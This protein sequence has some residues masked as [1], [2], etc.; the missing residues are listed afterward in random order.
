MRRADRLFQVIQLLRAR[1]TATAAELADE[2]EV[3]ERTVYRDVR[4]LVACG[5][6]IEG[7]AGVGYVLDR[8]FDLPPLM[9]TGGELQALALG[10][11]MASAFADPE[12]A[13]EARGA[14][15]KIEAALPA[16]LRVHL[17]RPPANALRFTP[18]AGIDRLPGLRRAI[19]ER[20]RVSFRYTDAEGSGSERTARPLAVHFWG[21]AWTLTAWCEL[22]DAFR[23]FRLDRIDDLDCDGAP[24][25][26]EPGRTLEAFLDCMAAGE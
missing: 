19:V 9:F 12:L 4:D 17:E 24:F 26:D 22:R 16:A 7:E 23:H 1:R 2:L 21:Q 5:V 11:S 3:S 20:R 25:E 14:L 10:A 18:V 6:P 8:S 15:A 13:R